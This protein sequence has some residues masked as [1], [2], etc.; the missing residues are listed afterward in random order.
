ML[1]NLVKIKSFCIY[2]IKSTVNKTK[3]KDEKY[4][5]EK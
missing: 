4:G 5:E 1:L 2:I 3:I